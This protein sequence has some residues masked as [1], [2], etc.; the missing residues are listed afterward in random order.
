[1]WRVTSAQGRSSSWGVG[2]KGR[3]GWGWGRANALRQEL[4]TEAPALL[5]LVLR[6]KPDG[7]SRLCDRACVAGGLEASSASARSLA[8]L[9]HPPGVLLGQ[10][11]GYTSKW[12]TSQ[13][14]PEGTSLR[15]S[16]PRRP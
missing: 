8:E 14:Q 10:W 16:L 5:G 15:V 7:D 6:R 13:G 12:S 4:G 9:A 11:R 1:M 2:S 3:S